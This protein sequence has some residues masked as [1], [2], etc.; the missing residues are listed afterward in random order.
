MTY[1]RVC[2][3]LFLVTIY[4]GWSHLIPLLCGAVFTRMRRRR[5]EFFQESL[6]GL[7]RIYSLAVDTGAR[8]QEIFVKLAHIIMAVHGISE[9]EEV[10]GWDLIFIQRY[11]SVSCVCFTFHMSLDDICYLLFVR[12]NSLYVDKKRLPFSPTF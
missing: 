8:G 10:Y 2:L 4:F 7:L 12:Q 6:S 5:L 11:M 9:C 3:E 1:P